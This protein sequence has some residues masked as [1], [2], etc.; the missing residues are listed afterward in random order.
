LGLHSDVA[1]I[2]ADRFEY[3]ADIQ[4]DLVGKPRWRRVVA[5]GGLLVRALHS[6]DIIHLNFG[7][8]LLP[9]FVGGRVF[10]ELPLLKRAGKTIL[11]T[12]QGCDVRPVE[13]CFCKREDCRAERA[14]RA[15]NAA[16]LLRYADR[17]FHLNPDL[18][19]WLPGSRFLPYASIDPFALEVPAPPPRRDELV[20]AHAPTD[21]D[22]KGTAHVLAA[23]EQL[24]SEG[25]PIRLDLIEGLP[26][27]ELLERL[28]QADVVVDQLLL[29]WYGGF[30][31]EAMSLAR[32]VLCFIR[33]DRPEDNP[34]GAELPIV[35]VTPES[36]AARLREL[37]ADRERPLRIGAASR[38]FVERHHAPLTVA[39]DVLAGLV[40]LPAA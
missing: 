33:E 40:E 20:V 22:V 14:R 31:V 6:Y 34:F 5:R 12:F 35:R 24:R 3:G 18:G 19:R 26:R 21:R 11:V 25:V 4:P 17:S 30:A 32:P 29:G 39:R 37:A 1:V 13:C 38:E 16:H 15:P 9:F 27:R 7:N 8:S 36:L 10:D 2:T 28:P 23:V